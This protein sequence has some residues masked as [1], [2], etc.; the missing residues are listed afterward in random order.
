MDTH[1]YRGSEATVE[2]HDAAGIGAILFDPTLLPRVDASIF[3][4]A[5]G[6][7]TP[8][9]VGGRG[10]AW[11]VDTA[12]GAAVLRHYRRGGLA[13]K[14]SH[15]AYLWQGAQRTRSF[16]EFRLLQEVRA[17]GLPAP[18]PLA[19]AY[20]RVGAGYRAALLVARIA[21]AR[22]LGALLDRHAAAPWGAI[23]RCIAAFHRAGV[24]HA[25]LNVDNVLMDV[26]DD[27]W[28]IDFDR[29]V[30]RRPALNWQTANIARLRRSLRK[31]IGAR[32]DEPA[33]VNGWEALLDGWNDGLRSPA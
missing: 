28:L 4:P 12:A 33:L 24:C 25:D 22:S 15:A 11:F 7:A 2:F 14:L 21:G 30:R 23:G 6:G 29:G 3:D 8:V 27:C 18:T 16:R 5:C 20:W 10:A 9:V 1:A 26:N 13:A 31:R 19:A 32:A 17:L